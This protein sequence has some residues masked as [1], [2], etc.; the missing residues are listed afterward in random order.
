MN[1]LHLNVLVTGATGGIGAA[2]ARAFADAGASLFLTGRNEVALAR[3]ATSL[4]LPDDRLATEVCDLTDASDRDGL[5]ALARTWRGGIHVL[6]NNA[7]VNHFGLVA[8][9]PERL[10]SQ[11]LTV[12]VEAP[13]LLTAALIDH[14]QSRPRAHIVNI[15]SVFGC[16]GY[17]G[18]AAY[19]ASKFA[20]RGFSEALRRE[21]ADSS[22]RVHHVA[23]RATDTSMND[24]AMTAMNIELGVTMDPPERVAN[25]VVAAVL[26][27]RANRVVGWPEK[28][29]ARINALF[30]TLV[31]RSIAGQL[32]T[33]KHYAQAKAD[34][35]TVESDNQDTIRRAS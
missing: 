13:M 3:T 17:P 19:S 14:L 22:V 32:P 23:P 29:F 25:E 9:Q 2:I 27:D 16:I 12:N 35:A 24:T 6:V 5:I 1:E 11:M 33:I 21:L 30:P 10:V 4:G 15:G 18:F 7:G 26:K 8:D 31:D 28:V 20:M 34:I